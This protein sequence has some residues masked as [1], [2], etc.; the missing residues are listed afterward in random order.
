MSKPTAMTPIILDY[1]LADGS[2]GRERI[3]NRSLIAWDETRAKRQ[4]PTSQDAPSLWQTFILWHALKLTGQYAGEFAAFKDT[5]LAQLDL[6]E[7]EDDESEIPPTQTIGHES[8][9]NW[10]SPVVP[11]PPEVSRG[12]TRMTT[13]S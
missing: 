3:L 1:E 5:D 7:P 2:T 9:S 12:G 8:P 6:Y 10:Q 11:S 13:D 4:W